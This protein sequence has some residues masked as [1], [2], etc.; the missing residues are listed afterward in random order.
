[1]FMFDIPILRYYIYINTCYMHINMLIFYG[2]FNNLKFYPIK[3]VN[4]IKDD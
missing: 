2:Y 3:K 4:Q 1:M